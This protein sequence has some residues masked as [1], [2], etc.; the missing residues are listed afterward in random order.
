MNTDTT[1]KTNKRKLSAVVGSA[2]AAIL[3]GSAAASVGF[4]ERFEGMVLFGYRD[5]IG[6][7]TK[8]A[9][10][11]YGVELGKR[12]T[13]EECMVSLE[14]GIIK[15]ALPV[16]KCSP[17]LK[18]NHFFLSA[19]IDQHYHQGN[20][21]GS[22]IAR[23]HKAGNHETACKRYNENALGRPQYVYVKDKFIDGKWTYKTLPGLVKRAAARR[24]LC[25]K[26]LAK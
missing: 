26:G 12:Y 11:T 13:L 22:S 19:A 14:Q 6:I 17:E 18:E 1:K 8:C 5:P 4:V 20:F 3:L 23:E 16:L 2:A 24:E 9:G 7:P 10:D 25:E 15:H 21:C